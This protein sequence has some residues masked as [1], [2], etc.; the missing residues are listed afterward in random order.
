MQLRLQQG[1]VTSG[2]APGLPNPWG[3]RMLEQLQHHKPLIRDVTNESLHQGQNPEI[4][5][6]FCVSQMLQETGEGNRR[7]KRD[8]PPFPRPV[9]VRWSHD[10]VPLPETMDHRSACHKTAR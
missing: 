4:L 3:L 8:S 5:G 7:T 10:Q 9:P 2:Q 6:G 1:I